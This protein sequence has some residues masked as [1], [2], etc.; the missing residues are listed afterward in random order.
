MVA[1]TSA[2]AIAFLLAAVMGLGSVSACKKNSGES[3]DPPAMECAKGLGCVGSP[4][5]CQDCKQTDRCKERG[6]CF[7]VDGVCGPDPDDHKEGCPCGCDRS[8]AMNAELEAKPPDIALEAIALSLRTIAKREA[9]GYITEAMVQHRLRLVELS[10]RLGGADSPRRD[11]VAAGRAWPASADGTLRVRQD[12]IVHG[13]TIERI[14][15]RDK[16]LRACFRWWLEIENLTDAPLTLEQPKIEARVAF[17]VS[18]WYEEG[19]DGQHWDGKLG[20][21]EKKSVLVIGYLG[22]PVEPGTQLRATTRLLA[23]PLEAS[24]RARARWSDRR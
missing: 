23:L 2:R 12:L 17:P 11:E 5:R 24:A 1:M 20:A 3:C 16:V 22:E 6:E 13:R 4:P 19:S 18:R 8:E 21:R 15:G 9:A 14:D 10:K 7:A